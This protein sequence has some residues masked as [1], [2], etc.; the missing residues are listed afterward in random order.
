MHVL[1]AFLAAALLGFLS[2]GAV[3]G[4]WVAEKLRGGVFAFVGGEWLQ[5]ERGSVV[6]DERV[7]RTMRDGRVEFRRGKEVVRLGPDTQV[8]FYDDNTAFTVVQQHFGTLDVE[9]EKRDVRHFAVQT[10]FV[11]AVVKGT[12]F[13]VTA[14]QGQSAEVSVSAGRVQVRDAERRQA[15]DVD[16]GQSARTGATQ[17]MTVSG[18]GT[19]NPVMSFEGDALSPEVALVAPVVPATS[20]AVDPALAALSGAIASGQVRV[21]ANANGSATAVGPAGNVVTLTPAQVSAVQQATQA[22]SSNSQGNAQ[23]STAKAAEKAAKEAEKAEEKA[24]KEAEKAEK[25]AEKAA[26]KAEKEAE[27]AAEKAEKDAEKAEKK[28]K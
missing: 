28:N 7:V 8:R 20:E 9:A 2:S 22:Q 11:A 17:S 27:K 14:Q 25:E 21:V 18:S 26:E 13:T 19:I 5:L 16:P 23:S 3:A 1:R 4:E 6:P 24:E 15:V 10:E 12:S